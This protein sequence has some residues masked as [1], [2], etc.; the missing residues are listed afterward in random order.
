M[1]EGQEGPVNVQ[2]P[3]LDLEL[4][5][6]TAHHA[7]SVRKALSVG[8]STVATFTNPGIT[9]RMASVFPQGP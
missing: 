9:P 2:G 3:S 7:N 8:P 6:R 4:Y 1:I 5:F